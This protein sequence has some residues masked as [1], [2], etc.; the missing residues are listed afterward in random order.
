LD[1]AVELRLAQRLGLKRLRE[2]RPQ[3]LVWQLR[4]PFWMDAPV[5]FLPQGATVLPEEV[6]EP[7]L[8]V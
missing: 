5:P 6:P 8:W 3:R 7:Q 2:A 4:V 1:V